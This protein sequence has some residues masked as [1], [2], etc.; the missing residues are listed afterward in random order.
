MLII[1]LLLDYC[2]FELKMRVKTYQKVPKIHQ[3]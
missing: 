2:I 3:K 1:A